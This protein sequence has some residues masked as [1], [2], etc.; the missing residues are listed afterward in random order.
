MDNH[1]DNF[2]IS[3]N[4]MAGLVDSDFGVFIS[5]HFPK[6]KLCLN[7][8]ISF[9]NTRFELI[10]VCHAY[11]LGN[12]INHHIGYLKKTIRKAQKTLTISR[13]SKCI[14]FA[15]KLMGYCVVRK[16]QLE[17]IKSF[18]EDRSEYVKDYG[19]K[20]SRTPYTKYQ[21]QLYEKIV[22]LNLN[23]NYDNGARNYTWSWL[24]GMIDGDGS[25][26]FVVNKNRKSEK[27]LVNGITK[28]YFHDKILPTI[29]ITT[30]SDTN[31]NNIKEIFDNND[32][33]YSV[34]ISK[35][36][37]KKRLG[38]NKKKS[39]YNISVRGHGS[40][41][42]VLNK[43]DGKL[44]GKQTQLKYMLEYLA[45]KKTNR[46]NTKEAF[47]IVEKV[48]FLNHNPNYKDISETNTLD[49]LNG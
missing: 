4:Y 14:E 7:P 32:I 21:Q 45:T 39:H 29:D 46:H 42:R 37:A 34:R 11:L 40:I 25:I 43:L 16:P 15:D 3:D 35:S 6:G 2:V 48:K 49:V 12:N 23:Y 26:C 24:A 20:P 27:L 1:A 33:K 22:E 38:K 41:E 8:V 36:K 10:E 18:C 9:V 19:W 5:R 28:T 44:I 13:L 17:I 31:L 47:D 30:G